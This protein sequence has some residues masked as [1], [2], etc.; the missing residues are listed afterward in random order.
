MIKRN[1]TT[2]KRRT[3][4]RTNRE[5]KRKNEC[6]NNKR[7]KWTNNRKERNEPTNK[8]NE[9]NDQTKERN[10]HTNRQARTIEKLNGM[11][12]LRARYVFRS[13]SF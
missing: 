6:A 5:R 10:K 13:I 9:R 11:R 8:R 12:M 7:T 1:A 4:E 3:I 2:N